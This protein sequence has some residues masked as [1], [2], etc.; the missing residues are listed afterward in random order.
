MLSDTQGIVNLRNVRHEIAAR[1]AGTVFTK[2]RKMYRSL[3]NA[4]EPHHKLASL[5]A[6]RLGI[7]RR[8]VYEWAEKYNWRGNE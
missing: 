4:G 2:A 3:L 8:R 1:D 6:K 7:T 5:T